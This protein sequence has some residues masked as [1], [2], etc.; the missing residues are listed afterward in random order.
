MHFMRTGLAVAAVLMVG[1]VSEGEVAEEQS[2]VMEAQLPP[3]FDLTCEQMTLFLPV[4]PATAAQ[5]VSPG[6]ELALDANGAAQLM[7]SPKTC[8]SFTSPTTEYGPLDF[9][10]VWILLDGPYE[11][12]PVPGTAVTQ[13]TLYVQYIGTFFDSKELWRDMHRIGGDIVDAKEIVV[14]AAGT[15]GYIYEHGDV[16]FSW[17]SWTLSPPLGVAVGFNIVAYRDEDLMP[18]IERITCEHYD[19]VSGYAVVSV[20][21]ES[22]LAPFGATLIG[23]TLHGHIHCSVTFEEQ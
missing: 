21:P 14:G 20:N 7:I 19:G 8:S 22:M 4:D 23:G 1:C 13:P 17:Q 11:V 6:R 16:G 2:R 12:L 3:D 9:F 5:F 10:P 15:P 18:S